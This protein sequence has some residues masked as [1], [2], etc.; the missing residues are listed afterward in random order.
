MIWGVLCVLFCCGMVS[1]VVFH[2][3]SAKMAGATCHLNL[4]GSMCVVHLDVRIELEAPAVLS[5]GLLRH[6]FGATPRR[7]EGRVISTCEDIREHF[8]WDMLFNEK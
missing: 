5:C 1:L 7:I 2:D 6:S 3:G 8:S 4:N